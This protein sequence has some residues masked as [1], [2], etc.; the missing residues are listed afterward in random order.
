MGRILN[1]PIG[2][3]RLKLCRSACDKGNQWAAFMGGLGHLAAWHLPG[4][5]VGPASRWAAVSNIEVGQTIYPVNRGRVGM[6]GREGSEGQSH[7]EEEREGRSRTGEGPG[8]RRDVLYFR[9]P[10]IPSYAIEH[11]YF[12][13]HGST[14]YMKRR[15]RLN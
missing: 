4:G 2:S 9:G 14:I 15:K 5:P 1:L 3:K 8:C 10:R 13:K 12:T 7:K 6:E 11:L